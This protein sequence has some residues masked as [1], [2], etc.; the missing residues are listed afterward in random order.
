MMMIRSPDVY[1]LLKMLDG[2]KCQIEFS[3]DCTILVAALKLKGPQFDDR[4]F[5]RGIQ[6]E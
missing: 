2:K 5:I 4:F 6:L 1:G 3:I